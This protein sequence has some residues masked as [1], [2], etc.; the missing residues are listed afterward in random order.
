MSDISGDEAI[1]R[2]TSS[3]QYFSDVMHAW[4]STH[5]KSKSYR[6]IKNAFSVCIVLFVLVLFLT[7]F[8]I[9]TDPGRF[10][11]SYTAISDTFETGRANEISS[12]SEIYDWLD[13]IM[14]RSIYLSCMPSY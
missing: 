7:T 13:D 4:K 6:Y 5:G 11:S 12:T 1:S 3:I 8:T 9:Q 10:V 14:N 2:Q